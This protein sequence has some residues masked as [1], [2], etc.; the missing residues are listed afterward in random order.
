MGRVD[1]RAAKCDKLTMVQ[2][3]PIAMPDIRSKSR[4]WPTHL[5]ST[6]PLRGFP[7]RRNIACRL[8]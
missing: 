1:R 6:P 4:F 3:L 5:H 8:V 2:Q 7:S